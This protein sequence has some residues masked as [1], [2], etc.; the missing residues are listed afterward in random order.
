MRGDKFLWSV[1]LY[2][3]RTDAADAC[4]DNKV[5]L[6]DNAV[7]PGQEMKVDDEILIKKGSLRNM[8]RVLGIPASR[9][10]AKLVSNYLTEITPA[11]D[12]EKNR[13]I[14]DNKKESSYKGEGRPTKVN[15]RKLDKW[16]DG[17]FGMA[18]KKKRK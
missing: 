8:Y 14:L 11:A 2:K 6:R 7:K 4:K 1:R 15:R 12:Q 9:V 13:L 3:T 16:N 18:D 10:G 5:V 17:L